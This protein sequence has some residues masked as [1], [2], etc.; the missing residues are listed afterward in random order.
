V[1]ETVTIKGVARVLRVNPDKVRQRGLMVL[2]VTVMY[3]PGHVRYLATRRMG[4][5]AANLGT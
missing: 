4:R 5:R 1:T 3:R 2:T